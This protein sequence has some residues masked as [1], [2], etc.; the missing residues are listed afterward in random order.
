MKTIEKQPVTVVPNP[1]EAANDEKRLC[2]LAREH[3]ILRVSAE[4]GL[5]CAE[6]IRVIERYHGEL[7]ARAFPQEKYNLLTF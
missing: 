1:A 6:A 5:T 7:K 3:N 4:N 2:D